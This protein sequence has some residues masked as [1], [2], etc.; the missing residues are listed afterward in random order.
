MMLLFLFLVLFVLIMDN[1]L[2]PSKSLLHEMICWSGFERKVAME[3]VHLLLWYV[4]DE[5]L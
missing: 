4:K 1:I 3:E 2:P 5:T